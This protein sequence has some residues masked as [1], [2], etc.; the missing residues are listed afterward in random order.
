MQHGAAVEGGIGM[1]DRDRE[2]MERYIY[3]V[4][5]RLPKDQRAEV[6]LE[7]RELIGD[8]AESGD[9]MEEVLTQLGDPAEFAEKYQDKSRHLIGPEYY[10]DYLWFLKVV[11]IC[12]GT[13]V[14]IVSVVQGVTGTITPGF[15]DVAGALGINM[16][17][18]GVFA[19]IIAGI[20]NLAVSC[21][22]VFGGVT[23]LFALMERNKIGFER[24][25]KK[26]WSVDDL[27]ED[28]FAKGISWTP[29]QLA[30]IPHKK[31]LISRG[32]SIIGIVFIVLFIMLLIFAPRL[33][34]AIFYEAGELTVIPVFNVEQWHMIL[35]LFIFGLVIGLADEIFRLVVGYYCRAV[36]ISNIVCGA[37]QIVLAVVL[38]KVFP[39]LNPNFATDLMIH[40]D[41]GRGVAEW[42]AAHWNGQ[43]ISNT[44]LA[45]VIFATFLEIGTTVY[46]TLRYGVE[47]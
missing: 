35:P 21:I 20:G 11:L 46:K 47:N 44:F 19:G 32:D 8:M 24:K 13:A 28:H 31:A 39:I 25:K 26:E 3:Q 38:L 45:I 43:T 22:G 17:V 36:M 42:I 41:R 34:S 12:A 33:F 1:S 4:V 14:F 27:A 6:A 37:V 5:K 10:D 23:L 40:L 29:K 16:A 30:P 9:A 7:L 15:L 2:L 18:A